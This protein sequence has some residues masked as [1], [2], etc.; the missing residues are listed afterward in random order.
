M[1]IHTRMVGVN[2]VLGFLHH[3]HLDSA[4]GILENILDPIFKVKW[5][6]LQI[7][8]ASYLIDKLGK[9]THLNLKCMILTINSVQIQKLHCTYMVSFRY[10]IS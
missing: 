5:V 9:K 7:D 2:L 8:T 1:S 3:V 6:Q 10:S 4:T